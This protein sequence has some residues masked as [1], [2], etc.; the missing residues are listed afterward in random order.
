V[1][2]TDT[3]TGL[4]PNGRSRAEWLVGWGACG[5]IDAA[6][7]AP[8]GADG[9]ALPRLLKSLGARG[10]LAVD[11]CPRL[12]EGLNGAVAPG[13]RADAHPFSY[14]IDYSKEAVRFDPSG[15]FVRRWLPVLARL[16]ARWIHRRARGRLADRQ[17]GMTDVIGQARRCVAVWGVRPSLRPGRGHPPGAA[18]GMAACSVRSSRIRALPPGADGV[19]SL[20]VVWVACC[21]RRSRI[22]GC[23]PFRL[24]L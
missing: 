8:H 19:A 16:P 24:G 10:S 22:P 18:H 9:R 1:P 17:I 20:S 13:P 6:L 3:L 21:G 4:S 11:A 14:M 5:Q 12:C 2:R 23:L 15:N 7:A